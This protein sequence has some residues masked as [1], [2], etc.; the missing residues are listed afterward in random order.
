MFPVVIDR[1]DFFFCNTLAFLLTFIYFC[2]VCVGG[3]MYAVTH[4]RTPCGH[5]GAPPTMLTLGIKVSSA[6]SVTC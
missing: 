2:I 4:E 5:H 1:K 3:D 6:G